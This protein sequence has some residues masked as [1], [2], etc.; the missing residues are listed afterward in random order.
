MHVMHSY[1]TVIYWGCKLRS[2]SIAAPSAT[3]IV[4]NM[5]HKLCAFKYEASP[6]SL[7]CSAGT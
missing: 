4:N 3:Q 7:P 1:A 2:S 6:E 5:F